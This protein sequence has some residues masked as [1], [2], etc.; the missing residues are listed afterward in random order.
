M[1]AGRLFVKTI[2][3]LIALVLLIGQAQGQV[4]D[5]PADKVCLTREQA[6]EALQNRD[7]V[8]ALEE[9][10]KA[11]EEA[12]KIDAETIA[13]LKLELAKMTGDKTGAEQMIVRLSAIVDFMLK[14]GRTK[15]YGIINF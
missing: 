3:I 7:K 6:V 1:N 15:K 8:K 13:N 11:L 2:F 14:N 4:S 12:R 9:R 5:C 10:E